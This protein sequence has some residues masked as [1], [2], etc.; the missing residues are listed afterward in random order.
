[1]LESLLSKRDF[2]SGGDTVFLWSAGCSTGEEAVSIAMVCS[3]V[4]GSELKWKVTA[5]DTNR[6]ALGYARRGIYP[7]EVL[8]RI[9]PSLARACLRD[10]GDTVRVTEGILENID[11]SLLDLDDPMA[12]YPR[13]VR[14]IFFRNVLPYLAGPAEALSRLWGSLVPGGVLFS[15]A[16]DSILPYADRLEGLRYVRT[17]RGGY[18]C[19]VSKL[20]RT[21]ATV[22]R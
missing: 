1:M 12:E 10:S 9:P 11:Y 2:M 7:R 21:L 19:K 13:G 15:G 6:A 14:C 8:A 4:C 17:K 16:S 20:C 5:T 3:R 22:K 18:F